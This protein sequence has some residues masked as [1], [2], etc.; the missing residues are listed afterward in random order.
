MNR[1]RQ[2]IAAR[3]KEAQNTA[4]MLTT[5]NEVDMRLDM[6]DLYTQVS[7]LRRALEGGWAYP[8]GGCDVTLS[9]QTPSQTDKSWLYIG[10]GGDLKYTR[11]YAV[12]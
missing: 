5:F 4:A 9:C 6:R 3:L 12:H 1:M 2:R 8:K 7:M 11:L 10:G